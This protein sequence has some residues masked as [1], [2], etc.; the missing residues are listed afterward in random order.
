MDKDDDAWNKKYWWIAKQAEDYKEQQLAIQNG[1]EDRVNN[2]IE[3][4]KEPM[5]ML[6]NYEGQT[7]LMFMPTTKSKEIRSYAD[8]DS[9]EFKKINYENTRFDERMLAQLNEK[10]DS[11]QST[12]NPPI[13][14]DKLRTPSLLGIEQ[15]KSQY[16]FP[17]PREPERIDN[18]RGFNVLSM[19][20]PSP[21]SSG[22]TPMMTWGEVEGTPL[23][24]S[25]PK[26]F[27]MQ[28]ASSRDMLTE[29]LPLE[30]AR[31]KKINPISAK[32]KDKG[33]VNTF[34]YEKKY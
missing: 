19:P 27:K 7:N 10:A 29:S 11:R 15:K 30:H 25:K 32:A 1:S 2:M 18:V 28:E 6:G 17:K 5:L 14:I 13:M 8:P 3:G 26:G 4:S 21:N 23:I 9:A 33:Y 22:Q 34:A 24:L 20:S 16:A 12:S 31:K